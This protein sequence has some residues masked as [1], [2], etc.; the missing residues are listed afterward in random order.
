[1]HVG[2]SHTRLLL[3]HYRQAVQEAARHLLP[4]D[5]AWWV[6]SWCSAG[7][8]WTDLFY[9]ALVPDATEA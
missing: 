2:C 4:G 1:M 8:E 5:K 3:P 7:A 9:S 6:A